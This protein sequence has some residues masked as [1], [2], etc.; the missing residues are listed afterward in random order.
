M[1]KL[2]SV[3]WIDENFAPPDPYESMDSNSRLLMRFMK[4]LNVKIL[5]IYREKV[6]YFHIEIDF[7]KVHRSECALLQQR[8]P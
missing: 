1:A 8:E 6:F 2:V 5:K 7:D 4:P 3:S